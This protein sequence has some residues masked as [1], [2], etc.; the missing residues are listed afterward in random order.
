MRTD[1][2]TLPIMTPEE[3]ESA[4]ARPFLMQSMAGPAKW[5]AAWAEKNPP[6]PA[7]RGGRLL[8]ILAFYTDPENV[9]RFRAAIEASDPSAQEALQ[10][11][12]DEVRGLVPTFVE[13]TKKWFGNGEYQA[14]ARQCPDMAM[15]A[16]AVGEDLLAA[17][18][19]DFAAQSCWAGDDA[20]GCAA[21]FETAISLREG[22]LPA[23]QS[24]QGDFRLHGWHTNLG[25]ALSKLGLFDEAIAHHKISIALAPDPVEQLGARS[26]LASAYRAMGEYA[27]A[28]QGHKKV[29]EERS[30]DGAV[31]SDEGDL[32]NALFNWAVSLCEDGDVEQGLRLLEQS[33]QMW[34]PED[35]DARRRNATSLLAAYRDTGRWAEAAA[36]FRE[37]W[38]LAVERAE[39]LDVNHFREGFRAWVSRI[40]PAGNACWVHSARAR[41]AWNVQAWAVATEE[42]RTAA[43]LAL[44]AR[45]QLNYLRFRCSIASIL[46]ESQQVDA[47]LEECRGIEQEAL[48]A[49][50]ALPLARC[51]QLR[52][53]QI[54]G[55]SDDGELMAL[56]VSA[57]A[58]VY[59][60]LQNQL[61]KEGARYLPDHVPADMLEERF[62]TVQ[63]LV[64]GAAS[65]A[66]AYDLAK[67]IYKEAISLAQVAQDRSAE[68]ACKHNLL[69]MLDEIPE[70]GPDAE[71]L[72]ND[73]RAAIDDDDTAPVIRL[74]AQRYLSIRCTDTVQAVEGLKAAAV[75]L[76]ALRAEQNPGAQRSDLDRQYAIYPTL[77]RRLQ[78]SDATAAEQFRV[79][80]AMRA[81]RLMETLTATAD[82]SRPYQP[83]EISELQERLAQL[84]LPTTFV[85]V[86][87]TDGGLRAYL[88]DE[89]ELRTCDVTGEVA[90]LFGTQ[91]GDVHERAAAVVALV[92]DSPI[93][94][95]LAEA[96]T[97][98]L[99]GGSTLLLAVDDKL[100]NLPMH[101][102]PVDGTPWGEVVSIGRIPAAGV[103]R[104]TPP[105][106]GWSGCSVVAGDSHKDLPGA[107]RECVAVAD[108]LGVKPIIQDDCTIQAVRD[109]LTAAPQQ[110]LDVVHLAVHGRADARRGGRSSLLFAGDHLTWVAFAELYPPDIG[111]SLIVLSGCSTAVGGPRNGVGL[112]GVAQAAAEAGVPTIIAS[113]WPIDDTSAEI[114][115][116]AFYEELSRR[117]GTGRIDL[118]ELMDH[119]R[120]QLRQLEQIDDRPVR[121]DGREL[122]INRQDT[123]SLP[124]QDAYQAAMMHWA[125]FVLIGEPTL[126]V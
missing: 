47:A 33:A 17:D 66:H 72:A 14:V 45:D 22:A 74:V 118:R 76:E 39:R 84:P 46:T 108:K 80:Q 27:L 32:A 37:T 123:E 60:R 56:A 24:R 44:A 117:R 35:V 43:R 115:M 91:Y 97:G 5:I 8:D 119:A 106:R 49:G 93:L 120:T 11:V 114:F 113:L 77:L 29:W 36:I 98:R 71:A 12:V 40:A 109:A 19:C 100:A 92:A 126:I 62:T 83:I 42:Y 16:S 10:Y 116:K 87:E 101:A 105:D 65:G 31:A 59:V 81:R 99:K 75:L 82:D 73:L 21:L 121:R 68:I 61:V 4:P 122:I 94:R 53:I 103:L 58:L 7:E 70:P 41:Q 85:D 57:E 54:Y 79:L 38:D 28:V 90:A 104:F 112:Y 48:A 6:L 107:L 63:A 96:V 124:V 13:E 67:K 25:L 102:I 30:S 55:G 2:A 111:T 23:N 86:T 50:L 51:A 52:A 18:M 20:H 69:S 89:T 9:Q 78:E 88:V 125:P 34:P 95:E 15:L 64:A 26:N 110:Q 1:R 3:L